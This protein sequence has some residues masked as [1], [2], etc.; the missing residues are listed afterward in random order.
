MRLIGMMCCRNEDWVIGL[1]A[2]VALSWCD[3]LVILDHASEDRS[4]EL[5]EEIEN[6]HPGRVIH[7]RET[8]TEWREMEMRQRMLIAAR[9]AGASHVAIIDADEVLTGNLTNI[10]QLVEIMRKDAL[11]QLP[12]YNLRGSIDSYHCTGIWADRWFSVAFA[13]DPRLHWG[14]DQF[15]H[16][17]PMGKLQP[18]HKPIRQTQGGVMH[19]WGVSARR[20]K[21]KHALYKM[22]E[23]LRWPSKSRVEIN[24]L[25]SLAF[26]PSLNL[27]F[28]QNWEYATVPR[29]W[30]DPYQSVMKYLDVDAVPWQEKACRQLYYLHG[31]GRFAG[32]DLFD[33]VNAEM[34]SFYE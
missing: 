33:V 12:G 34:E 3:A 19:L 31:P 27:R 17:E 14:G 30:W 1:S 6:E 29:S 5:L 18:P 7:L 28:E 4:A 15:H 21:A 8:A 9:K 23:T 20:L 10:R 2:R 11:L 22:V 16:R 32:L 25:Y 26:V 13:D 24:V